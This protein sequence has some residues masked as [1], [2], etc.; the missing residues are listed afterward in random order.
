MLP[1]EDAVDSSGP[2]AAADDLTEQRFNGSIIKG[3]PDPDYSVLFG[4]GIR[5]RI[6]KGRP[7]PDYS[8]EGVPVYYLLLQQ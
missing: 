1:A 8:R 7:D 6:I 5:N 2:R 3:R 4:S